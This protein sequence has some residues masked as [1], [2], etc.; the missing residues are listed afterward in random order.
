MTSML[1]FAART[2][3]R[4]SKKKIAIKRIMNSTGASTLA[5]A[6]RPLPSVAMLM[7][8]QVSIRTDNDQTVAIF[9]AEP[10]MTAN[11]TRPVRV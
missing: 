4:A 10:M 8:T 2:S 7:T 1:M 3:H 9:S 5:S 11:K 6:K